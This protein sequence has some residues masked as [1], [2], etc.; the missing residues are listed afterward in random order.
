M[1]VTS[2]T[3]RGIRWQRDSKG[4]LRWWREDENRWVRYHPG[5]DAPPRPKGWEPKGAAAPPLTRPRWLSPYRII[6]LV[7]AVAIITYGLIQAFTPSTPT[8]SAKE[9]RAASAFKG[10]C[11]TKTSTGQYTT[12]KVACDDPKAAG[13]VVAVVTWEQG[14]EA[15]PAHTTPAILTGGVTHPHFECI[16]PVVGP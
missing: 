10:A 1:P 4:R 2:V 7:L 12:T 13:K 15:C 16:E 6:P 5:D 8:T 14:K 3:H 11:L 9:T